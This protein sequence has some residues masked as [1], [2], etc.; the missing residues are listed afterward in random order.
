MAEGDNCT[1][2]NSKGQPCKRRPIKG[3]TV[4]ATHGGR[5]PQVK[6]AAE[7][8]LQEAAAREAADRIGVPKDV[9]PQ[10]G[11][12]QEVRRTAGMI[13]FYGARVNELGNAELVWGRTKE[14]TGGQDYGTTDEARP[15]V[16][17]KL[18]NEERD[19][20]VVACREAIKAGIEERRVQLAE[21][22]GQVMAGVIRAVLDAML[23]VVL[24]VISED[25]VRSVVDR[26]WREQVPVVVPEQL[27]ILT[28]EVA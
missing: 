16:W 19:R 6:A 25:R 24:D 26:V 23:A 11:L 21:Q 3:G 17:L 22:Q 4:C 7:R 27:R 12:L 14:K 2:L 28:Q 8:R 9:S 15:S 10:E 1:A 13:D 20:F 5:A 18:W